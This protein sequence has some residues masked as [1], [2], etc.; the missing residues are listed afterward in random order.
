M[1]WV[2]VMQHNVVQISNQSE[3][4]QTVTS[5]CT[6]LA[7]WSAPFMSCDVDFA[8]RPHLAEARL[9]RL[10]LTPSTQISTEARVLRQSA[11]IVFHHEVV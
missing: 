11:T 10:A 3:F 2:H 6:L 4:N 1:Q 9:T 5:W 7:L 8:S